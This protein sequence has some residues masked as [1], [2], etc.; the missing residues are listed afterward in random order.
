MC[1]IQN[2]GR[3]IV[4]FH[5]V[6][7][8]LD[9]QNFDRKVDRIESFDDLASVALQLGGE[10]DASAHFGDHLISVSHL[11][12]SSQIIKYE[13]DCCRR[14]VM[15]LL[16][17]LNSD[18]YFSIKVY[19]RVRPQLDRELT[20]EP[21]AAVKVNLDTGTVH[22]NNNNNTLLNKSET[23]TFDHVGGPDTTQEQVFKQVGKV[24]SDNCLQGYNGTIFAYGQ[25]G[26]GK[27]HTMQGPTDG[28]PEERGI[29]PRCFEYLFGMIAR[30]EKRVPSYTITLNEH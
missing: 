29:I 23:F 18:T 7:Q 4:R 30:E 2:D 9:R 25:T 16:T 26:S 15:Q 21:A 11:S 8:V 1:L 28:T 14:Q 12:S 20:Q 24:I 13:L 22:L 3:V 27:T 5:I 17:Q 10:L 6:A 19:F